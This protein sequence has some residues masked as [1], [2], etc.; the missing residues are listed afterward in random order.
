MTPRTAR[1]RFVATAILLISTLLAVMLPTGAA[2]ASAPTTTSPFMTARAMVVDPGTG[3]VFVSG[4]DAVAVLAPD[5]TLLSTVPDVYG[6]WGIDAT[7]GAIWVNQSTDG[8][9]AK[10]DPVSMTVTKRYTVGHT[11]GDSLTIIGNAAWIGRGGTEWAGIGRFD[12][13]TSGFTMVGSYYGPTARRLGTSTTDLL[14]V[15]RG[16]SGV[17]RIS[18]TTPYAQL[19]SSHSVAYNNDVAVDGTGSKVYGVSYLSRFDAYDA[20]TLAPTGASYPTAD[21]PSTI[22]WSP[23]HGGELVGTT[24][25]GVVVYRVGAQSPIAQIPLSGAANPKAFTTSP[26]GDTAY[27]LGASSSTIRLIDLRPAIATASPSTVVQNVPATV[28]VTGTALG[29]TT[30]ASIGGIAVTPTSVEPASVTVTMPSGV[31]LGSQS[32]LL[33][34]PTGDASTTIQ[35]QANTGGGL[36][37]TVRSE[38]TPVAGAA[39]TLSGGAL[40]APLHTTSAA[41]GSYAF[42]G[43]GYATTYSMTVHDPTGTAPDQAIKGI[44]LVPNDLLPLDVSLSRPKT[45]SAELVRTTIDSTE[46][47]ALVVDPAS[48]RFAVAGGTEVSIF[49][50]G[51]LLIA[52]IR[53]LDGAADLTTLDGELYVSLLEDDEVARIDWTALTVTGR[54]PLGRPTSGSIAGAGGRIWFVDGT[55]PGATLAALDPA[56]GAIT[57]TPGS[58]YDPLLRSVQGAPDEFTASGRNSSDQPTTLFDAAG[59][60]LT[61]IAHT[62]TFGQAITPHPPLTSVVATGRVYDSSGFEF[63]LSDLIP[64]GVVYA[65]NGPSAYS[66][67]HGGVIAVGTTVDRAGI[68]TASHQFGGTASATGLNA[69]GDRLFTVEGNHLVVRTLV[70]TVASVAGP[71]HKSTTAVLT[72]TGLGTLTGVAIDGSPVTFSNATATSVRIGIPDLAP[73]THQVVITTAWG[74]SQP[75]SFQVVLPTVPGAPPAPEAYPT[76]GGVVAYWSDPVDDGGLTITGFTATAAPGGATCTTTTMHSCTISGLLPA[77]IVTLS[78][79]ATNG[80]GTGPSSPASTPVTIPTAPDAPTAVTAAAGPSRAAL[81]WL[82]PAVDGG[83][84]VTSYTVCTS[85]DPLVPTASATCTRT[86]TSATVR[87]V[88]GLTPHV[89][90]YFKVAAENAAGVGVWSAPTTGATP[91][92]APDAPTG[93][94]ATASRLAISASWT[95]PAAD[96]GSPITGYQLCA[97]DAADPQQRERCATGGTTPSLTLDTVEG[98]TTYNV[99]V[100]ALNAAGGGA[101]SAAKTVTTPVS[102][103]GAPASVTASPAKDA[104]T[105]AWHGPTQTGG[106]P[107]TGYEVCSSTD[108]A[109]P[110]GSTTCTTSPVATDAIISGLPAGTT[111]FVTVAAT[112]ALGTGSPSPVSNGAIPF[113]GASA[114]T[115]VLAEPGLAGAHL[116]WHTPASDGGS[117]ITGY[118]V[119]PY[120]NGVAQPTQMLPT[121]AT[122]T[123][124]NGLI[125]HV[126]YTFTVAAVNAG[127]PGAASEHTEPV[128]PYGA[129]MEPFATWDAF[130]AYQF[131]SFTGSPGTTA[132]RAAEA[133]ILANGVN[134]PE[135]CIEGLLGNPWYAPVMAPT[136]RL[137]WAYLGRIPDHS[138]LEYWTTKRRSGTTLLQISASFAASNEFKHTYG[139]LSS[140]GFV[141]LVY[142]NVLGRAPDA[143]GRKYWVG[144]LANGTSRAQLM[145]D[146]S[147]SREYRGSSAAA[148]TVVEIF[149]GMVD[150]SPTKVE[151]S[152]WQVLSQ[153]ALI[154]H[155]RL[156]AEYADHVS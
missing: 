115:A 62:D 108:P 58:L 137:Y 2:N 56:T 46:A 87:S 100:H 79:R 111:R 14:I 60:T 64:D 130:V 142:R 32:L 138:G 74:S 71:V 85:T 34:G 123:D 55:T 117:P 57:S 12:L 154:E 61:T 44:E 86:G 77:S 33:H 92:A 94:T 113:T 21:A 13:A 116:T 48:G 49:D 30:S 66:A 24:F 95:A 26:D 19:A 37:G 27:L 3:R 103:P 8:V 42:A 112:N 76:V 43:V 107:I 134:T 153:D 124:I 53:G 104:L 78:V 121:V 22:T 144:R 47:S 99:T 1:D 131:K 69:A 91:F 39:V 67:G 109:M 149:A 75:T 146:F 59:G 45:G 127:G 11:L 80:E 139:S 145:I 90:Y 143:A 155:I 98:G 29:G 25:V 136:A 88:G 38:T 51:G 10:I 4:D 119:T 106:S 16:S 73:G 28:T 82:A 17:Y 125:K 83:L 36:S 40:S 150:R 20:S 7:Q 101:R 97:Q 89:T 133:T 54:W 118:A 23:G 68:P 147:E 126:S 141:D 9:I 114:P 128:I 50:P 31:P 120:K 41:D 93:L 15:Q 72:G 156:S 96:G 102:T 65:G 105:V 129:P 81:Q 6:A 132:S 135:A 52:R 18:A 63:R 148:V 35:V 140:G 151:L 122:G 70:P 5:G 152:T 110:A 84:V